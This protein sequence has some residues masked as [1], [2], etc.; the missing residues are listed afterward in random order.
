MIPSAESQRAGKGGGDVPY[1][2]RAAPGQP[3]AWF[4]PWAI[5]GR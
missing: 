2:T 1:P 3:Y 4:G 5:L